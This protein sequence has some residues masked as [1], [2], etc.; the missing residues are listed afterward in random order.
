MGGREGGEAGS[1]G[2]GDMAPWPRERKRAA[3]RWRRRLGLGI[4]SPEGDG[5]KYVY[6]LSQYVALQVFI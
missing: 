2:V 3:V 4:P 5:N 1:A 6:C